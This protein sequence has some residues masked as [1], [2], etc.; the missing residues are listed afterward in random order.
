MYWHV[1]A[2]L[3]PSLSL[4]ES[5]SILA[6]YVYC[7]NMAVCQNLVPLVNIKIAGK[8]M[9]IP[10]KMVLIGIDPTHMGL[11]TCM[12]CNLLHLFRGMDIWIHHIHWRTCIAIDRGFCEVFCYAPLCLVKRSCSSTQ[13]KPLVLEVCF[14]LIYI[15]M[16][17][18]NKSAMKQQAVWTQYPTSSGS[19][20]FRC[21]RRHWLRPKMN[22]RRPAVIYLEPLTGRI[23]CLVF[24]KI[25]KNNWLVVWNIFIFPIYWEE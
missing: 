4:S 23:F 7:H 2:G 18:P 5:L 16:F 3:P 22:P 1:L 6:K 17:V 24:A 20:A 14:I 11:Y 13:K 9:F 25:A 15:K 10:L 12:C 21:L 8:W 19:P